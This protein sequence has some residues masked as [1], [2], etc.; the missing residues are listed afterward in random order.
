MTVDGEPC[1]VTPA[2]GEAAGSSICPKNGSWVYLQDAK[3]GDVLTI[4]SEY[5]KLVDKS[6]NQWT[7][8]RGYGLSTAASH[9]ST[10]LAE[11]CLARDFFHGVGNWSWTWDTANDPHG[12][13]SDGTT[14][15]VAW[16]YDHP[17]PRPD[18]TLGGMPSYDTNCQ[19]GN[20]QCT[21][22]HSSRQ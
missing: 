3:V 13:N 14:V 18:V 7:L 4:D 19:T 12:L 20:G 8:Q 5:V 10:A 17:V 9:S 11:H 2:A 15:R 21:A 6:G 16:D 22:C 1:D